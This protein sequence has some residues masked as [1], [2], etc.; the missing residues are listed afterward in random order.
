MTTLETIQHADRNFMT[1]ERFLTQ[2]AER[3]MALDAL[4]NL[5]L[6]FATEHKGKRIAFTNIYG[7]VEYGQIVGSVAGLI[8]YYPI[9]LGRL[10]TNCVGCVQ[11]RKIID[12]MDMPT[13]PAY[14]PDRYPL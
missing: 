8:D 4:A 9:E 10:N 6:A 2:L 3:S 5:V 1:R 12:V 11:P 13:F 14:N 7:A